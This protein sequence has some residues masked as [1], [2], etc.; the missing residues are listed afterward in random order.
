LLLID[1]A[2]TFTAA[3]DAATTAA[4]TATAAANASNVNSATRVATSAL[5]LKTC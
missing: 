5:Q 3:D 4:G 2:A 1:D